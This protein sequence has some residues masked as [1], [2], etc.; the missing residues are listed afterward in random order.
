MNFQFCLPFIELI[1]IL[2]ISILKIYN[3]ANLL[4]GEDVFE[5]EGETEQPKD[6]AMET[7]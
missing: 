3:N 1:L 5:E 7:E 6:A 4:I 2:Y